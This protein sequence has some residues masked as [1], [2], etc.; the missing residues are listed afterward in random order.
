MILSVAV[1]DEAMEL[2]KA[3][4]QWASRPADER[5]GSLEEMYAACKGYAD[6]SE[7]VPVPFERL[8]VLSARDTNEIVLAAALE[9]GRTIKAR[10]THHAFGQIAARAGIAADMCRTTLK[11]NPTMVADLINYGLEVRRREETGER[12]AQLLIHPNGDTL[13]RALT[14]KQYVRVWNYEIVER[15][16]GLRDQGWQ[17]PPAR[18][19]FE[20]QPGTR[21]AT[22]ADVLRGSKFGLSVKVGDLIAPAGL[23]ASDHDMFGFMVFDDNR[24]VIFENS[25]VGGKGIRRTTAL[26]RHICGNHIIWGA[27]DVQTLSISHVGSVREKFLQINAELVEYA[28]GAASIEEAQIKTARTRQIAA[29]KEQVL[30]ALFR[31]RVP[32]LGKEAIAKMYAVAEANEDTDGSPFSVW[33]QVNAATRLSQETGYT[34]KRNALDVAAGKIMALAK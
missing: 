4:S 2:F 18:P 13:A 24:M 29:T 22:E 15:L 16:I 11:D 10:L 9:S 33:A 31:L 26:Y 34:D 5:F 20:G 25:E 27:Q 3:N 7:E 19:A 14:T 30:D 1:G 21:P 32:G 17:V 6:A 28:N 23:Y 8:T 12:D